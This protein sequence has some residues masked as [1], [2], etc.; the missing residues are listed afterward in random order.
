MAL[1]VPR[2]LVFQELPAGLSGGRTRGAGF[3]MV[4]FDGRTAFGLTDAV[5]LLFSMFR[6]LVFEF[7][8]FRRAV[9]GPLFTVVDRRTLP[10]AMSKIPRKSVSHTRQLV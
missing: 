9:V 6:L 7:V 4:G 8:G 2:L 5:G 10:V 1:F 3:E